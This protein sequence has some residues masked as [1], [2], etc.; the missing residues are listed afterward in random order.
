MIMS[1]ENLFFER[2]H[3]LAARRKWRA[4]YHAAGRLAKRCERH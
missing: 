1:L 3:G 2:A 4:A